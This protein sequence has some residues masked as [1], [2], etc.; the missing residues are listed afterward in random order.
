MKTGIYCIENLINSKQYIG[1][2]RNINKRIRQ[3]HRECPVVYKAIKKYGNKNFK[4][5][6]ILYCE[7]WELARYEIACIKI[8]HSHVSENGYNVSWGGDAPMSG[9]RHT[10]KTKEKM[11]EN[12]ACWNLGRQLSEEHRKN[13]SEAKLGKSNANLGKP[14]SEEHKRKIK[15]RKKEKNNPWLGKHHSEETKEK[16]R[17]NNRQAMLGKHISEETK[18]KMS[19]AQKIAW[20]RKKEMENIINNL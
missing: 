2:G 9:R 4:K 17:K 8:F 14:L 3:S 18:R 19:D 13:I 1:Q 15:E 12:N 7:E 11:R 20:K 6:I 10:E 5:L 16:M